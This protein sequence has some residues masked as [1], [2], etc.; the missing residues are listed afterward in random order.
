MSLRVLE[1]LASRPTVRPSDRRD[2]DM[3]KKY[4]TLVTIFASTIVFAKGD[5][6]QAAKANNEFG[7]KLFRQVVADEAKTKKDTNILISSLSAS[8]A[9][10]MAQAGA[11]G[12]TQEE[13]IKALGFS[14]SSNDLN[15]ATHLLA[16]ELLDRK[17]EE[18]VKMA[19]LVLGNSENF[20]ISGSYEKTI[21]K[22]Y[23]FKNEKKAPV[24]SKNFGDSKTIEE[25][26]QWCDANTDGDIKEI[27][28]KLNADDVA[29]LLNALLFQA[30]WQS[31]FNKDYTY[32][33]KGGA[34]TKVAA[35]KKMVATGFESPTGKTLPAL[36]MRGEEAIFETADASDFKLI[37]MPFCAK[38]HEGDIGGEK[39]T[40][41]DTAGNFALDILVPVEGKNAYDLGAN[42]EKKTYEAAVAKLKI[43]DASLHV[44]KFNFE[45][46]AEQP[47]SLKPFLANLGIDRAFKAIKDQF[48][49]LGVETSANETIY[50]SDVL[51][52]TAV[53]MEE[54]GFKAS[55]VT[56]VILTR[57]TAIQIPKSIIVDKAFVFAL[58]DKKTNAVLFQGLLASPKWTVK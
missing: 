45:Y 47:K 43:A 14:G 16:R 10:S 38:S 19:N 17:S 3:F 29:V 18:K 44:P 26:N 22:F 55:A 21:G 20:K 35:N 58:R 49:E 4:L 52:K 11:V 12:K 25:I 36:M 56:A 30:K 31:P 5:L 6:K 39:Q 7:W 23:N 33:A 32:Q 51:Q 42:L 54:G 34:A 13:I 9:L 8:V 27:L 28:K 57:E 50:I 53:Q 46:Q 41:C 37:S 24:V 1:S 40:I 48:S 15:E 2:A